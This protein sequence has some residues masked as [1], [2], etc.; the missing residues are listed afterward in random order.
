MMARRMKHTY[1][2][3]IHLATS[4]ALDL[5]DLISETVPLQDAPAAFEKNLNYEPGV[6]KII[7]A[8]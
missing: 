1:P 3:A 8:V 5:E 2:R 6:Q 7:I 4:G